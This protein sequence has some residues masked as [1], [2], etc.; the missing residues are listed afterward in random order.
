[1]CS[2]DELPLL[3]AIERLIRQE[4]AVSEGERPS[5]AAEPRKVRQPE[6]QKTRQAETRSGRQADN[7]SKRPGK[8]RGQSKGRGQ[9]N[10]GG[11]R[12]HGGRPRYDPLR[13]GDDIGAVAFMKSST[14][15]GSGNTNL[16]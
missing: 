16:A 9:P 1:L 8:G 3:K 12:R 5:R 10:G 11:Q 4:I 2:H 6:T 7:G 13:T 15:R 14:G